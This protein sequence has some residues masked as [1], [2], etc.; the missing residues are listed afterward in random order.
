MSVWL[1]RISLVI[2][3]HFIYWAVPITAMVFIHMA[4]KQH[5]GCYQSFIFS[6]FVYKITAEQLRAVSVVVIP[7][8]GERFF[9]YTGS[10]RILLI[11]VLSAERE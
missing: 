9:L 4:G 7:V 10:I 8:F 3:F 1:S 2:P 5:T 6:K 11:S